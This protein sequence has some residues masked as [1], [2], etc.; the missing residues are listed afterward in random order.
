MMRLRL[1]AVGLG[2]LT[3]LGLAK[4]EEKSSNL[5]RDSETA[6]LAKQVIEEIEN[7]ADL[8]RRNKACV[9]FEIFPMDDCQGTSVETI[10]FNTWTKRG[11]RCQC[12]FIVR[13]GVSAEAACPGCPCC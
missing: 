13:T 7:V 12:K 1:V 10:S 3:V 5:R 11:S 2:L 9:S 6:I 8:E 4:A